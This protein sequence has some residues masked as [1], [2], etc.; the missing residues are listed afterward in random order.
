MLVRLT[1]LQINE[2]LDYMLD[3]SSALIARIEAYQAYQAAASSLTDMAKLELATET[4]LPAAKEQPDIMASPVRPQRTRPLH[5]RRSS[6]FSGLVDETPLDAILQ[7]L[8][9]S[10]PQDDEL[11]A[12]ANVAQA[13]LRFLAGTLGERKAKV[14]DVA[15]DVQETFEGATAKQIADAKLAT[16]LVRD[17]VLAESQ[18]GDV[19]L[20][21]PEIESSIS[22]LT[23][24]MGNVAAKLQGVDD[25]LAKAR[26]K[27]AKRDELI[28]RWG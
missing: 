12:N 10:L 21:D 2:C 24:E 9:I 27:S 23:Q 1:A 17:S 3:R 16:Q 11:P 18:F 6:A 8:A 14:L 28:A 13:Q 22:V 15:R 25:G 7:S 19:R 26:G 4:E 20:M 5:K